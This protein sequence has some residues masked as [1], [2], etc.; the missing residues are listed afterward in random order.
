MTRRDWPDCGSP[1]AR[2]GWVDVI[3]FFFLGKWL[4]GVRQVHRL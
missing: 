2:G 1:T 3:L 4:R